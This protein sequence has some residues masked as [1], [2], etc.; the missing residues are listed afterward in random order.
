MAELFRLVNY[1]ILPRYYQHCPVKKDPTTRAMTGGSIGLTPLIGVTWV[2]DED[3]DLSYKI[4]MIGIGCIGVCFWEIWRRTNIAYIFYH[5]SKCFWIYNLLYR[6][7]H[8]H[9][10]M[11]THIAT[12]TPST[13]GIL[14]RQHMAIVRNISS[15]TEKHK[16]GI[17]S[18]NDQQLAIERSTILFLVKLTV[19]TDTF[20]SYM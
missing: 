14:A 16:F 6:S 20:N 1:C 7:W 2:G 4:M 11:Y 9:I 12:L 13:W 10:Y 19:S 8:T 3:G 5:Y 15:R 17:P 18:G